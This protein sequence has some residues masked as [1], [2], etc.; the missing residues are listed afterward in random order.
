LDPTPPD[1]RPPAEPLPAAVAGGEDV[2]VPDDVPHAAESPI[3]ADISAAAMIHRPV[4]ATSGLAD[5]VLD[6]GRAETVSWGLVG[7]YSFMMA[8]LLLRQLGREWPPLI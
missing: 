2:A 5:V 4:P 1:P 8:F 6:T 7:S 3:T